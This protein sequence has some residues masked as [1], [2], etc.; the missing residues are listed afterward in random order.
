MAVS[1]V[2]KYNKYNCIVTLENIVICYGGVLS[3]F[4]DG[5]DVM[6]RGV[7]AMSSQQR[8]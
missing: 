6:V 2:K 7:A 4:G 3:G 8:R 1:S 5:S